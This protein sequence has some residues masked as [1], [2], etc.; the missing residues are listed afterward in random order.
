M[1]KT[2]FFPSLV[3][4][5]NSF[6]SF[7]YRGVLYIYFFLYRLFNFFGAVFLFLRPVFSLSVYLNFFSVC[8]KAERLFRIPFCLHNDNKD[9]ES[10]GP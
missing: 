8:V 5:L 6:V 9:L 3:S 10:L 1:K 7:F 2:N 4:L